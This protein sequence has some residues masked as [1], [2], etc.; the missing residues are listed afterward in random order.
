MN[1]YL[2][3][4]VLLRVAFRQ[5]NQLAQ[6]SLLGLSVTSG[7]TRVECARTLDRLSLSAF[8]T[9]SVL[10]HRQAVAAV[11]AQCVRVEL[12]DGILLRAEQPLPV[13]LGTLDALHLTSALVYREG[14]GG[15]ALVFATHDAALGRA[16][17]ALGCSVIGV[18]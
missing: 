3:S 11:L 17:R 15:E 10:A 14:I 18:G 6:W 8:T 1:A 9:A 4:S 12:T 7:L 16:A 5:P 13:P 2:D